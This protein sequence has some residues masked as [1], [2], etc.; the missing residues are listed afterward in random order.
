MR[1]LALVFALAPLVL[2]PTGGCV[3][4]LV[5]FRVHRLL[6]IQVVRIE[7]D[8]FRAMVRCEVE[9]PNRVGATLSGLRFRALLGA[10]HLLGVGQLPGPVHAPA[11]SKFVLES[12][13]TV[14][15]AD[16]P[17]DF[18]RREK[19]GTM[20]LLS[21]VSFRAS[22]KLGALDLKL[23]SR[24]RI[25]VA[26][27]LKVAISG[28]FS[29]PNVAVSKI[30]LGGLGLRASR[31]AV[32]LSARNPLAFPVGVRAGAF[33]LFIN[34]RRAGQASLTQRQVIAPGSRAELPATLEL[35]HGA[36]GRALVSMMVAGVTFRVKGTLEID[37]I[38]G[39]DTLPI[40]I[41]ADESVL[42]TAST[43]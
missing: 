39:V 32:T 11:R 26:R 23:R 31:L 13:I 25:S 22:S 1:G 15:Y 38:G 34:G 35:N 10:K 21:V 24:D 18:P 28:S 2:L 12:P 43:K 20:D 42:D 14:R 3:E 16:L 30:S 4:R 8:S 41:T 33:T 9:N 29:G 37:P 6:G 17:A 7:G 19:D 27:A 36:A 5:A 40:D